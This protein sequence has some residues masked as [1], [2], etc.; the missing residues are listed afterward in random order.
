MRFKKLSRYALEIFERHMEY[1][2][3]DDKALS[4]AVAGSLHFSDRISLCEA[5]EPSIFGESIII[6]M[7]R[8]ELI[9][10]IAEMLAHRL[11]PPRE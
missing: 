11:T 6:F 1:E 10:S 2:A 9:T 8:L 3:L 7:Y 4:D 5:F